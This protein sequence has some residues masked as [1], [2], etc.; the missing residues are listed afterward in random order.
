MFAACSSDS[1]RVISSRLWTLAASNFKTPAENIC[2][3]AN[4][5]MS[6]DVKMGLQEAGRRSGLNIISI[7]GPG[8][9]VGS[10]VVRLDT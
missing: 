6:R 2:S 1:H 7:Q 10:L 4:F 3:R 5:S 8:D 9:P